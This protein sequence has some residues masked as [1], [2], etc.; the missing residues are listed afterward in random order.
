MSMGRTSP[1]SNDV[2]LASSSR[3]RRSF[4]ARAGE[5][6]YSDGDVGRGNRL[7]NSWP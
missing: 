1:V 4:R 3:K 6:P 5:R 2:V 7:K